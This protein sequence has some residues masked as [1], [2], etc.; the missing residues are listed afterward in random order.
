MQGNQTTRRQRDL[1]LYEALLDRAERLRPTKL[2]FEELRTLG[3]LY[4]RHLAYLARLR[5]RDSD[6]EAII[7]LNSLAVRAYT[8]LY[9]TRSRR[10]ASTE[11]TERIIETLARGWQPLRIAFTLLF[12]GTF[13]GAALSQRDTQALWT[14]I[15]S[16]MGYTP[17][18]LE[19]LAISAREQA[20]FL[21]RTEHGLGEHAI[22]GS[23]LF[24]HNTRVGI[25]A[26]AT[27]IL[28]GIPTVLLTLYN[29]LVLGAFGSIFVG[30][31]HTFA[32]LAWIL[33]HGVPEFSAICLCAA[34]GLSLGAALVAPGK[35]H[36]RRA[37]RD[38][39]EVALLFFAASLPLFLVAALLESF[40][41]ESTLST[42]AR[43]AIAAA[44][45]LTL[46]AG[47]AWIR[48]LA[49]VHPDQSDWLAELRQTD[50]Y[51]NSR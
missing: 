8:L 33:P 22:F 50:E 39:M 38:A 41:R 18:M 35:L 46:V 32:F 36:R 17:V 30:G 2:G 12:I 9:G 27:G 10:G 31:P 25:M 21:E 51:R 47:A 28:A 26:L 13:L 7:H 42:A 6:P 37:I 24:A 45:V 3:V 20:R 23:T 19:E 48:S 14:V 16:S 34:G 43:L 4:R 49:R 15:P 40:V 1:G 5:E 29:G 44:G 11:N